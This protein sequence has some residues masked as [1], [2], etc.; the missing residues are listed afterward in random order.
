M[1]DL[2]NLLLQN[3]L[4]GKS[5]FGYIEEIR[6]SGVIIPGGVVHL[7]QGE[8]RGPNRGFGAAHIW[9]EHAKEMLS[10]GFGSQ[11]QV[12]A[13][14]A[15]IIQ[16]GSRV[17]YEAAQLRGGKRVSVVRSATGMAVLE[18]KGTWGNPTYSVVT[19]YLKTKAHGTLVG[20]VR[21]FKV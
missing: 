8:H 18:H 19:A 2:A 10:V 9:A 15:S 17:Y 16:P 13:F 4:T 5:S 11:D 21:E 7:K 20:T 14:V 3:P 6:V 1:A 12:P